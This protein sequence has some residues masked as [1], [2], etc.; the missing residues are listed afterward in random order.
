MMRCSD[1]FRRLVAR[2]MHVTKHIRTSGQTWAE[3]YTTVKSNR[4]H[5]RLAVIF[6]ALKTVRPSRCH[7]TLNDTSTI[8]RCL[9]RQRHRNRDAMKQR[10]IIL[11]LCT[12]DPAVVPQYADKRLY[13]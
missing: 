2:I 13:L 11:L 9:F 6:A 8:S 4:K 7:R 3:G 10:L 12:L 1:P 5:R